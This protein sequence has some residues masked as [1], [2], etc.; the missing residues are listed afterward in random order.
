MA[1][2][3]KKQKQHEASVYSQLEKAVENKSNSKSDYYYNYYC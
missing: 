2:G 1:A 3:V